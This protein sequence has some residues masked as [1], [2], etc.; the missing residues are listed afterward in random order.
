M[1]EQEISER[2]GNIGITMEAL[3]RVK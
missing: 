2:L 1:M 3:T